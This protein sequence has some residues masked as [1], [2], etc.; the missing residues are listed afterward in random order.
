QR[1]KRYAW[2]P[3]ECDFR[4]KFTLAQMLDTAL[5]ADMV[6]GEAVGVMSYM[7]TAERRRYGIKTGT[8]L[9]M[10]TPSALVQDTV[11]FEG[12]FQGVIHD[13]NGRPV[14]YR[15]EEKRDG[16]PVK[17]DYAAFDA[18]GRQQVIHVFDP[19]AADDVRGISR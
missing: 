12:L 4:G 5:T 19:L 6:F 8:K 17:K 18:A 13:P 7:R 16:F 1:W 14:A 2:N 10:M 9:C 3:R 15:F 11:E